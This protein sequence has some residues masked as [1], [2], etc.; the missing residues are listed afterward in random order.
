MTRS[1]PTAVLI[2]EGSYPYALGGVATWCDQ[3]LRGLTDISWHVLAITDAT[4][5]AAVYPAPRTVKAITTHVTGWGVPETNTASVNEG[6]PA[7]L[8]DALLSPVGDRVLVGPALGWCRRNPQG[9]A[10][11]FAS[12]TARGRFDDKLAEICD[13]DR[14]MGIVVPPLDVD[15]VTRFYG[16]LCQLALTAAVPLPPAH[17]VYLT[18]P[19]WGSIPALAER[20]LRRTPVVISEHASTVRSAYLRHLDPRVDSSERYLNTRLAFGLATTAYRIADVLIASTKSQALWQQAMGASPDQIRVIPPG[21]ASPAPI[22]HPPRANTVVTVGRIDPD[23]DVET[24]VRVAAR[25]NQM[26]PGTRFVHYGPVARG[27]QDYAR[28]CASLAS[29]LELGELLQFRGPTPQVDSVFDAA[30][31]ALFTGTSDSLPF[32]VLEAMS[33]ARPVVAASVG[34]VSDALGAAGVLRGPGDVD[35]LA[36]DVVQLLKSPARALELGERARDR[37]ERHFP[38]DR[39]IAGHRKVLDGLLAGGG[40]AA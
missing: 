36:A 6:L 12:R 26:A 13:A 20:V 4:P 3:L 30:D 2:T 38:L 9:I 7:L 1:I 10:S 16:V 40:V 25:A 11:S 34:S 27:Q 23:R 21:V 15:T 39:A 32:A 22:V 29:R 31:V 24:F 18:S 14:D 37:V 33:R 35:A 17:V 8:A 19:A 28:R 5:G